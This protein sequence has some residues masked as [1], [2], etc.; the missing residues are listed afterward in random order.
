VITL[1]LVSAIYGVVAALVFRRFTNRAS[2]R[3]SMNRILAHTMELGLFLDSPG[4]VFR[5]QR[6]LLRENA[7]LL[8]QVIL[9]GAIVALLFS[10]LY[11]A[12]DAF[13]GYAPLPP[14]E[15]S[16]VTI[17]M[18]DAMMPP[19]ELEAPLGMAVE[20]PGV[21]S[22]HD[23]QIS[24][25]VRPLR[26]TSGDLRFRVENRVVTAGFFLRDPAI[27]SIEIRFPK[28]TILGFSWL[29]WF[30]LISSVSAGLFWKR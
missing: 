24:W 15:P 21:R 17:Q 25:R 6:D 3:R 30:F 9:P 1:V 29:V 7:R 19:V 11:P 16:V 22:L 12:M 26:E 5:A 10:L 14:G 2:I 13:Y 23:R 28:S 20:T 8:R 27:R 4:L 18:K